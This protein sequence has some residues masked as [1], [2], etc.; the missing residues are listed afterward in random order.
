MIVFGYSYSFLRGLDITKLQVWVRALYFVFPAFFILILLAMYERSAQAARTARRI[1]RSI[2]LSFG[3][4]GFSS[5]YPRQGFLRNLLSRISL[6]G[7]VLLMVA[8]I[9]LLLGG[10]VILGTP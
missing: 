5:I 9:M 2:E 6:R 10:V 3:Q 8:V 1:M 4:P 7:A